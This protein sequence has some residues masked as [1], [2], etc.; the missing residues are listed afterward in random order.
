MVLGNAI[1]ELEASVGPEQVLTT[2]KDR[3]LYALDATDLDHLPD[4]VIFSGSAAQGAQTLVKAAKSLYI[5]V[6]DHLIVSRQGY[7]SLAKHNLL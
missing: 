7:F 3:G 6:H 5:T 2:A 4:M 1:R